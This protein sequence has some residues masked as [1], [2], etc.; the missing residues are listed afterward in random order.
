VGR[1]PEKDVEAV[2]KLSSAQLLRDSVERATRWHQLCG[3]QAD[4]DLAAAASAW[5]TSINDLSVLEDLSDLQGRSLL[6][7]DANTRRYHMHD[8]MRPI[9]EG[10]F[11]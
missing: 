6:S 3:F 5:K 1:D 11:T 2:L 8:L 7:F 9:A 10:L 4:F